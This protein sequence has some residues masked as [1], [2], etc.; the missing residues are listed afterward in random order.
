MSNHVSFKQMMHFL[1]ALRFLDLDF[2]NTNDKTQIQEW[3]G[4]LRE[5]TVIT[6]RRLFP[7]F[8]FLWDVGLIT[9][10]SCRFQA[11]GNVS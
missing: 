2:W 5:V 9:Y 1:T 4:E 7:I 10:H 3:E 11:Y 8:F 6:A